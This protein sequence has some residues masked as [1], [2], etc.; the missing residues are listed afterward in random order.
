MQS[1]LLML[2]ATELA[3]RIRNKE[4]SSREVVQAHIHQ[5]QRVN[6]YLNA[7]VRDRFQAALTEADAADAAIA[8]GHKKLPPL[9]GV[10]CSIKENFAFT[11]MPQASGLVSRRHL[12]S[13]HDAPTVARYRAA[14][15]IGL[16]VTNTSELCMWMESNNRVY[17][18]SNNPYDPARIVGGSSGG[19]GAIIGS[20]ASPFGL[21]ADVGGSIRMPAFF[22][23]VFGH[24]PTPGIVPNTGQV[25][26]PTG[27]ILK[28]CV[29]GPLAR[30]AADLMPL[31]KILAGPDKGDSLSGSI[32]L[33][34]LDDP[35]EVDLGGVEVISIAGNG[36]Y[37]VSHDM[38]RAQEKALQ[39]LTPHVHSVRRDAVAELRSSF[40]IWGAMMAAAG[41]P[42]FASQLG[43]GSDIPLLKEFGK[44]FVRQSDHTLPALGLALTE[45]VP[46]PGKY[47]S[48]GA[49]LR[50]RLLDLMG[51]NGVILFPP[52]TRVAPRHYVPLARTFD[53]TYCGIINVMQFPSTQVPLG[54]DDD[55]LPLG[56]QVIGPPGKD[57]LTI[58][59]AMKLEELFGGWVPPWRAH[60][61]F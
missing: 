40:E 1:E 44:W 22:N 30:R 8:R 21:G 57:H 37:R 5:A 9:H 45:K 3:R 20:G 2:S 56:V 28:Y 11:G 42:S 6:P 59:V 38:R 27:D 13:D 23:G 12:V 58:A 36:R 7:I 19:E 35:A 24:K 18:R 43:G 15:A 47:L 54:L 51:D 55:G 33:D 31:L 60:R 25:P 52:Y 4:V 41:G 49:S 16:G 50:E 29:T 17:G 32:L 39:A 48:M 10:P 53:W 14:G 34:D 26:M 61:R 46:L